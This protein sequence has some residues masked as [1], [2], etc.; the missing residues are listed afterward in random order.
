[1][2]WSRNW[3]AWE[4]FFVALEKATSELGFEPGQECFY[5]GHADGDWALQPT[6]YRTQPPGTDLTGLEADLFFEF[7]ARARELH[8]QH[9]ADWDVLFFMRHHGVPTRLLDWTESLGV[10]LFFAVSSPPHA[11]VADPCIWLLNPYALNAESLTDGDLITPKNLGYDADEDYYYDYGELLLEPDGFDWEQPIAL[12]P[13]QK[14]ARMGAQRGWFT[15][16]GS[17]REPLDKQCPSVVRRVNISPE[18]ATMAREFLARMGIDDYL[19]FQ[20]LDGLSRSL[21]AKFGLAGGSHQV[22][23]K[24]RHSQLKKEGKQR[25]RPLTTAGKP[26]SAARKR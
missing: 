5:R 24:H 2:S 9:L 4:E 23:S 21:V 11:G 13:Q 17:R 8:S 16:F 6:L 15:I 7:Q 25:K 20:D 3:D 1:M 14:S 19:L 22:R 18:S 26:R 10:A 12:Y